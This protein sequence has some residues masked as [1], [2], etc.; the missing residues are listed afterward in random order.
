MDTA[1]KGNVM[2]IRDWHTWKPHESL[3]VTG[4]VYGN[5]LFEDG[6][7]V[8]T[9]AV[10]TFDAWNMT[11]KTKNSTYELK[12][13]AV[14]FRKELEAEGKTIMYFHTGDIDNLESSLSCNEQQQ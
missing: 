1:L 6:T 14:W 3:F 4:K 10:K 13:P 7:V 8:T 5:P 9:S 11:I 12:R 2:E